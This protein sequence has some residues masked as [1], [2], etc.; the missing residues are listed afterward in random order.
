[1]KFP[2]APSPFNSWFPASDVSEPI[3]A[4]QSGMY[5]L[6]TSTYR[7]PHNRPPMDLR[8]SFFDDQRNVLAGWIS[9]WIN[10]T[11][12]NSGKGVSPIGSPGVCKI[13]MIAKLDSM[14]NIIRTNS[15]WVYPDGI[16]T[17]E[18]TNS[19]QATKY[20][21]NFVIAGIVG[22]KASFGGASDSAGFLGGVDFGG[23]AD[24][25]NILP[26]DTGSGGIFPAVMETVS[27]WKDTISNGINTVTPIIDTCTSALGQVTNVYSS[28]LS[29]VS[30][31]T[32]VGDKL[33]G[34]ANQLGVATNL[35]S[36]QGVGTNLVAQSNKLQS[37]GQGV[38]AL[39]LI[40]IAS[41]L[42][43]ASSRVKDMSSIC[44]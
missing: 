15:Y 4:L 28:A 30:N 11:I 14:K 19:A 3:G 21:V 1:M 32:S 42:S 16:V 5:D 2:D 35:V 24:F 37:I 8:V 38:S 40:D 25:S 34:M 6:F 20:T 44:F 9:F 23:L 7:I 17:F 10:S 12:L 26:F 36:R 22:E 33:S 43:G 41:Q 39:G 18:G 31:L 13:V 27:D 29:Y